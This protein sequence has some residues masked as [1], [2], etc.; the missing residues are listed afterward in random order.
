M[1]ERFTDRARQIVK[2]A[3]EL[4]TANRQQ[5]ITADHLAIAL[6]ASDGTARMILDAIGADI[7]ALSSTIATMASGKSS[8]TTAAR[9]V[10]ETALEQAASRG[11]NFIGS[12]HLLLGILALP[13]ARESGAAKVLK[14]AG[15]TLNGARK[16]LGRITGVAVE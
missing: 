14:S 16:Q 9:Y 3:S 11:Q 5:R 2:Q 15:V 7:E 13:I 10:I 6:L 1:Y 4:A 12:E 8:G